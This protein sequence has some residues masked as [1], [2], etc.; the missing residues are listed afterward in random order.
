MT[1]KLIAWIL[2]LTL[3]HLTK[4]N[5]ELDLELN[6]ELNLELDLKLDLQLGLV[7]Q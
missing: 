7:V 3:P 6:P 2:R 4:L 1:S 5:F